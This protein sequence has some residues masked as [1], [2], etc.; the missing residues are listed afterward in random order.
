MARRED[1]KAGRSNTLFAITRLVRVIQFSCCSIASLYL[2]YENGHFH[3]P[4]GLPG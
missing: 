3:F 2:L 1:V 4:S